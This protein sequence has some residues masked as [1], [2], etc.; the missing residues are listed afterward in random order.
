MGFMRRY[1]PSYVYAKKKVEEGCVGQPLSGQGHGYRPDHRRAQG[2]GN[3]EVQRPPV[4][5]HGRARRRSDPLVS[6]LALQDGACHRRQLCVRRNLPITT[7]WR[8][9]AR[10]TSWKTAPWGRCTPAARQ[11]TAITSKRRSS[12]R[13]A[14]SAS[15]PFP[16]KNLAM[17]YGRDGVTVECVAEF[18]ERFQ[19]GLPGGDDR[20]LRPRRTRW[21][22]ART[23]RGG[24]HF[25]HARGAPRPRNPCLEKQLVTIQHASRKPAG[26]L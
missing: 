15:A 22:Q 2:A 11:C 7:M 19:R 14:P 16:Q 5:G 21:P 23:A 9:A 26:A 8:S 1:D 13:R 18:R 4:R 17:L 3:G 25:Q 12:A 10:S 20:V 6:R 24:R